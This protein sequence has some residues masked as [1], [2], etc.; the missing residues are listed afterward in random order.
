MERARVLQ[1]EVVVAQKTRQTT[2][3]RCETRTPCRPSR[4]GLVAVDLARN[5]AVLSRQS[6]RT[7]TA[8]M[9]VGESNF[10]KL[11]N[12]RVIRCVCVC[13]RT[14]S[15][16]GNGSLSGLACLNASRM[17]CAGKGANA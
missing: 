9:S 5:R 7:C 4:A 6:T 14:T 8:E 2:A 17:L 10:K 3:A 13:V 15:D 1:V 12:A 11:V 16:K